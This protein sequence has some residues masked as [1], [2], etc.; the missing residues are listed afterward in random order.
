[1]IGNA[2]AALPMYDW[3]QVSASTDRLWSGIRDALRRRGIAAPD[4]L[5]RGADLWQLWESPDLMLA[6]T[7]G[8]PFRTRLHPRVALAG[9]PD[10]G[11]PDCPPG[12][13]NSVFVVRRGEAGTVADFAGR[14]LA[15]NEAG[16]Q[17]GWA[18]P[19]NHMAAEGLP[20]FVSTRRTGAHRL[21]AQAVADGTADIAAIDAVTWRF[22]AAHA[23][24]VAGRLRIAGRTALTPGLPYVT[25]RAG[26][27]AAIAA[28]AGEAIA[29]LPAA[30]RAALGLQGLVRIPAEAYLAVPTPPPPAQNAP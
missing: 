1:M 9:T 24:E 6:Q 26:D 12:H 27:A 29:G 28:A 14:T 25:A 15:Y 7:C 5:T 17:S 20:A 13:Y 22:I 18:A 19:Q 16:S 8:M 2:I 11:L 21:S 3:P 4:R 10:F 23:P 30:D